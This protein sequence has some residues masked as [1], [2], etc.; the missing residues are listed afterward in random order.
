M[1]QEGIELTQWVKAFVGKHEPHKLSSDLYICAVVY[2]HVHTYTHMYTHTYI[3]MNEYNKKFKLL[4]VSFIKLSPLIGCSLVSFNCQLNATE[5]HLE[6]C[7][8]RNCPDQWPV[9][10]CAGI[11]L[12]VNSC[13][14]AWPSPL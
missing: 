6:E 2:V 8:L 11:I 7:Q 5:N 3:Q 12:R 1:H 4:A 13:R 10:M 14:I 9:G